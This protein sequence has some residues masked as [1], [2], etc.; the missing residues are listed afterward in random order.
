MAKKFKNT[1]GITAVIVT[2]TEL[3]A[4]QKKTAAKALKGMYAEYIPEDFEVAINDGEGPAISVE[5]KVKIAV[6]VV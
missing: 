3:T 2:A 5:G 4:K 6:E 1:V